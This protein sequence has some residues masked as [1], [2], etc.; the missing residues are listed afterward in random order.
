MICTRGKLCLGI[1]NLFGNSWVTPPSSSAPWKAYYNDCKMCNAGIYLFQGER[2]I[3]C[4][5]VNAHPTHSGM[6]IHS[7]FGM[8]HGAKADI[9][10]HSFSYQT[11]DD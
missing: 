3:G 4:S 8:D 2:H 9:D 1:E 6:D 10:S 7:S 11:E 5:R